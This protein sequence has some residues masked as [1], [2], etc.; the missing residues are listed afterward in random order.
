[1]C[2]EEAPTMT[3]MSLICDGEQTGGFLTPA[4][5]VQD[6]CLRQMKRVLNSKIS[7]MLTDSDAGN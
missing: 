6:V 2:G 1:M 3:H 7:N 5:L 4:A